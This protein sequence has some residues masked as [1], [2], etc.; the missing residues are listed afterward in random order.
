MGQW[1]LCAQRLDASH[2]PEW[3]SKRQ[4]CSELNKWI[5]FNAQAHIDTLHGHYV[6]HNGVYTA[7]AS[8]LHPDCICSGSSVAAKVTL[9]GS[10][11]GQLDQ[12]FFDFAR[13]LLLETFHVLDHLVERHCVGWYF[14]G[15]FTRSLHVVR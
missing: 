8:S 9:F 11:L 2:N 14:R 12:V 15:S 3:H 10:F 4:V 13:I 6:N 5:T 1:P 7:Q